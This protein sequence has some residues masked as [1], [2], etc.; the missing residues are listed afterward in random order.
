MFDTIEAA[1][2]TV[3]ARR[4]AEVKAYNRLYRAYYDFVRGWRQAAD[5][6]KQ[7]MMDNTDIVS[8]LP[9]VAAEVERFDL[10]G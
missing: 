9:K 5:I 7:S 6:T 3:E 4:A 8:S 2:A 1:F 10:N